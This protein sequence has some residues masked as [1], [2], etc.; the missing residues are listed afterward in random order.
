MVMSKDESIPHIIF[1][2]PEGSGKKTII[3]IFLELLY[4]KN[5]HNV[6]NT[7]YKVTGSGNTSKDVVI[8]QSNYHIVI[9]P[10]NNNFDRYLI[11]DVVK[12]Y[13]KRMPLNVFSKHKAFK[14][15]VINNVDNLSFYAQTSLRRTMELYSNTCRFIMWSCSLSKVIDPLISR[16][17]CF[18][19]ASPKREEL[20]DYI[21]HISV[22][23]NLQLD[24]KT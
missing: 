1:Y 9:E 14:T 5:V 10:N 19:I 24:L 13:A 23:E 22:K 18:Q 4:D 15:V 12:E 8:K 20:F 16:S 7:I 6:T 3:N 11:Q 17:Y 21:Y 2:G